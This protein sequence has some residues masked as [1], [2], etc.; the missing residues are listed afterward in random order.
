M[1]EDEEEEEE[2]NMNERK[3]KKNILLVKVLA[4]SLVC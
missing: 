4:C 1:V 2:D 3:I